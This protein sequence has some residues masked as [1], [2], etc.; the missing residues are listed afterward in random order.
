MFPSSVKWRVILAFVFLILV[1]I[2]LMTAAFMMAREKE[3]AGV[4]LFE[5]V[6]DYTPEQIDNFRLDPP[7]DYAYAPAFDRSKTQFPIT[8]VTHESLNDLNN[9]LQ[10][11][12]KEYGKPC[13]GIHVEG[14]SVYDLEKPWPCE[15]HVLRPARVEGRAT[16]TLGHEVAHCIYGAYHP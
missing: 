12:C 6:L 4:T 10:V 2:G 11:W 15:V 14:W 3:Q 8:I 9:A 1:F 5:D 16:S 13:D 7:S